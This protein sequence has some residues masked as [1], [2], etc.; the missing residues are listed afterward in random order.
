MDCVQAGVI[1]YALT[2]YV[3]PEGWYQ[4]MH[5]DG[6]CSVGGCSTRIKPC[7]LGIEC[8]VHACAVI[9]F[10]FP[11]ASNPLE[12]GLCLKILKT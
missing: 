12:F 2:E 11:Q 3:Q 4:P 6:L 9:P 5:I 10:Y 1:L 8:N 7:T